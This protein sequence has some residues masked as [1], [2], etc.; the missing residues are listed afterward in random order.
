DELADIARAVSQPADAPLP[1]AAPQPASPS[2]RLF[3]VV[4]VHAP[5][6]TTTRRPWTDGLRARSFVRMTDAPETR[7]AGR[8]LFPVALAA[9]ALLVAGPLLAWLELVSPLLGLALFAA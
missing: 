1:A 9:L 7:A 2:G 4:I 8:V 3:A 6:S 5:G